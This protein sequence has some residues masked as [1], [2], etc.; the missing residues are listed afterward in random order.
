MF[1]A[2]SGVSAVLELC[3]ALS[4]DLFNIISLDRVLPIA[5][6]NAIESVSRL[7]SNESMQKQLVG[8]GV[9][10]Q[11]IPMLL[12]YDNTVFDDYKGQC[13]AVP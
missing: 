7:C 6:E 1:V 5:V 10:W 11:L 2:V 4:V 3:P 12:A 8:A 9:V 13:R